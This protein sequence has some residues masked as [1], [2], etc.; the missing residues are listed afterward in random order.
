M[1]D[2]TLGVVVARFQTPD[3][4]AGH[5]HL[6]DVVSERHRRVLVVLGTPRTYVPTAKNPLDFPT[7]RELVH[8]HHPGAIVAELP[9]CRDDALWSRQL[10]AIVARHAPP[11]EA[12]LYGSR[13]SFLPYYTGAYRAEEIEALHDLTATELRLEAVTH[14]RQTTD[15]RCGVIYAATTRPPVVYQTVDVAVLD[16]EGARVLL[17]SKNEDAGLLRFIGGFVLPSDASLEEAARREAIEESGAVEVGAPT[18]LGSA[19]IDDWRYRVG[20]DR[21]VTALYA[22]PYVFGHARGARDVD[23]NVWVPEADATSGALSARLVPEH[24][25]LGE[26][27]ARHLRAT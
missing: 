22:V 27:L 7:R 13:D 2:A 23:A 21:I 17:A 5:R 11:A 16:R 19:R 25:P 15:F 6:L 24:R 18:Y 12:V 9:D 20:A 14:P 26:L 3:L 8:R 1:D 10:D 4:H